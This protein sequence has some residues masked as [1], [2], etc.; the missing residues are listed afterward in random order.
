MLESEGKCE[1]CGKA[2]KFHTILNGFKR[3]C[4]DSCA[5]RSEDHRQAVA[6][7]FVGQPE[8]RKRAVESA[9]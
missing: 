6:N 5:M 8:K 2:T 3:F 1:V 7:R 9:K 4:S